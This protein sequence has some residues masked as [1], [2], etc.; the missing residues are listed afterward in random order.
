MARKKYVG[1]EPGS[2]LE[3]MLLGKK[4]M[5]VF[6]RAL[7]EKFDETGGQPFEEYVSAGKICKARF[8]V[9]DKIGDRPFR[10]R[11]TLYTVP[12]E[13]WR[14]HVYK[15]IVEV[16]QTTWNEEL[17]SIEGALLGYD[18]YEGKPIA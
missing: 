7:H 5:A 15:S 8:F 14:A 9:R 13:E 11:F 3:L 12:G 6:Y 2:E 17:E 16:C 10:V 4:P 18:G 1:C